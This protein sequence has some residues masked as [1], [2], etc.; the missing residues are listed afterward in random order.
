MYYVAVL[1]EL[2]QRRVFWVQESGEELEVLAR[3]VDH[4]RA[5]LISSTAHLLA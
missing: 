2:V 5:T 1:V 3:R 4:G